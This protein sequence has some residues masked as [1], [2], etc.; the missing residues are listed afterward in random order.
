TLGKKV[1]QLSRF[2][3]CGCRP[4]QILLLIICSG[5]NAFLKTSKLRCQIR[6]SRIWDDGSR[7][8]VTWGRLVVLQ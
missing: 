1:Y 8:R 2:T 5:V 7:V 6:L 4:I 3:P